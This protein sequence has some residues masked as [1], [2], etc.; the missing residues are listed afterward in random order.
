MLLKMPHWAPPVLTELFTRLHGD[1]F[2]EH[3]VEGLIGQGSARFSTHLGV[4]VEPYL[5]FVLD[6]KKP[7]DSRFSINQCAPYKSISKGDVVLLKESGGP[8]VGICMVSNVWFY[9][10]DPDSWRTIRS[11]FAALLCAT[12]ASFWEAREH[13]SFATLIRL[14]NV[15]SVSPIPCHKK[16]RRGWVVI[17]TPDHQEALF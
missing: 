15:R 17:Q 8:I 6:G 11:D 10:L 2:W 7:I 13:A 3:L 12:E 4:F 1:P 5:G 16:D 9:E 14:K